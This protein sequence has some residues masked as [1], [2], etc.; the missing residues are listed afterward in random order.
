[1]SES[2][3]AKAHRLLIEYELAKAIEHL[4]ALQRLLGIEP[5]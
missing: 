4:L 3:E 2:V 5:K 1:M